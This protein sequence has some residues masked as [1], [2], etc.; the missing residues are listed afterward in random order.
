MTSP[1]RNDNCRILA[2]WNPGDIQ[3]TFWLD[4][5]LSSPNIM[6][7]KNSPKEIK[8]LWQNG[9]DFLIFSKGSERSHQES[10]EFPRKGPDGGTGVRARGPSELQQHEKEPGPQSGTHPSDDG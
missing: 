1:D 10:V 7:N 8:R 3:E 9:D 4:Y 5:K 2:S 6:N